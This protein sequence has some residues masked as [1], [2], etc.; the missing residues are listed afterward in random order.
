[1]SIG[2]KG[3]SWRAHAPP[4]TDAALEAP[5]SKLTMRA[6]A[7]A[8][9]RA[10]T[11]PAGQT[12]VFVTGVHLQTLIRLASRLRASTAIARVYGDGRAA[13]AVARLD[14]RWRSA[15]CHAVLVHNHGPHRTGHQNRY[16]LH[17]NDNARSRSSGV[18]HMS[19]RVVHNRWRTDGLMHDDRR[20][21]RAV[22]FAR[23]CRC[24]SNETGHDRNASEDG[25][26]HGILHSI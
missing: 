9:D 17:P 10:I 15:T 12:G 24:C 2:N 8:A 19:V 13:A 21:T 5:A 16:P 4:M 23:I 6:V 20:R 18:N 11:A 25:V 3:R 1:M 7:L 22:R 14:D 26:S